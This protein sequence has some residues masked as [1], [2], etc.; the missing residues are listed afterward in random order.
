MATGPE[1]YRQAE[2][3]L[4]HAASAGPGESESAEWNQRQAQV[5]ATLALAAFEAAELGPAILPE[6]FDP[7]TWEG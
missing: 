5:H 2:E 6:E 7:G 3:H 1:H 4:A